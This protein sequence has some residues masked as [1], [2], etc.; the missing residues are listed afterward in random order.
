MKLGM[1]FPATDPCAL[2]KLPNTTVALTTSLLNT[3]HQMSLLHEDI[4]PFFLVVIFVPRNIRE[5]A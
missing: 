5:A 4:K 3:A 1:F 2:A